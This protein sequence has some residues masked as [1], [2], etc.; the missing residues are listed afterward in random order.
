M[1]NYRKEHHDQILLNARN[2]IHRHPELIRQRL[3]SW[4]LHNPTK[5]ALQNK[6]AHRRDK[7]RKYKREKA[8]KERELN[9]ELTRQFKLEHPT[10]QYDYYRNTHEVIVAST[11]KVCGTI[12]PYKCIGKIPQKCGN[13]KCIERSRLKPLWNPTD[14]LKFIRVERSRL[15]L[16]SWKKWTI[17]EILLLYEKYPPIDYSNIGTWSDEEYRGYEPW[18]D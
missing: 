17:S 7:H 9:R 4:R 12:I 1:I 6:R 11:C 15:G 8:S 14:T 18:K 10:Y 5:R 2:Y 13:C 16:D 3:T